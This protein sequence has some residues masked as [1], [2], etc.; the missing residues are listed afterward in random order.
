[1]TN[2]IVG[3]EFGHQLEVAYPGHPQDAIAAL[4][5]K[6]SWPGPTLI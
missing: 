3:R 5:G 1:M 6:R 2:R 4:T